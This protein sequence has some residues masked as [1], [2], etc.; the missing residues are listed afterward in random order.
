MPLFYNYEMIKSLT[1]FSSINFT[2]FSDFEELLI[3]IIFNILY[4][5]FLLFVLKII[6]RV[7]LKI[8]N[9]IF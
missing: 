1:Y 5:L 6:Y 9:L 8:L 4:L 7:G 2:S 3:I